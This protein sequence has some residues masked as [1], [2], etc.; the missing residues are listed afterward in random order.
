MTRPRGM[1]TWGL[2]SGFRIDGARVMN[3]TGPRMTRV[4]IRS[5]VQDDLIKVHKGW[6]QVLCRIRTRDIKYSGRDLGLGSGF[7][8][9]RLLGPAR[10]RMQIMV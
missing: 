8:F 6:D 1:I 3:V 5:K 7:G 9:R 4:R 2:G 10:V